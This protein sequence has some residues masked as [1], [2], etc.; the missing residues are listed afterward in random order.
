M[1]WLQDSTQK[2]VDN[3]KSVRREASKKK[4]KKRNI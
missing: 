1:Q 2:I 4:K 3:L